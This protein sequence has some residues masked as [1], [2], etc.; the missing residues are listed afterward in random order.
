MNIFVEEDRTID[1]KTRLLKNTVNAKPLLYSVS[2]G[3]VVKGKVVGVFNTAKSFVFDKDNG[4]N[5]R[6]SSASFTF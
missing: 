2:T 4:K 3:N 5:T 1:Y 6:Y